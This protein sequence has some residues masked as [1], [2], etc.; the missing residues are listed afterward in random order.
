[1]RGHRSLMALRAKGYAPADV[2]LHVLDAEPKYRRGTDPETAIDDRVRPFI[3]I[4]PS[5]NPG[6]LDLRCLL[7]LQV[8]LSGTNQSRVGEVMR[9]LVTFEPSLV[10]AAGFRDGL[11][12]RWTSAGYEKLEFPA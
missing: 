9:R 2:W 7:G 3:D 12:V 4:A 8:H 10:I 5:D 6:S 1:M 11:I